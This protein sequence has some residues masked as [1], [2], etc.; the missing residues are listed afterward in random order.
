MSI[1]LAL[2]LI[3]TPAEDHF[4]AGRAHHKVGRFEL[5]IEEYQ[6][7]YELKPT[8]DLLFNIGQCHRNLKHVERAIFFFD[9][10]LQEA[11]NAPD[12]DAVR[13]LIGELQIE[14][15]SAKTATVAETVVEPPPP[16]I[17]P[18]PPIEEETPLHEQWWFWTIIAIGVGALA[19]GA[20]AIAQSV[21]DEGSI[22]TID[23]R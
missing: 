3:A 9:R 15:E 19:G 10:Y 13:K 18:P 22:G 23:A 8:P 20:V 4:E 5:A 1:A 21:G 16:A 14:L 2:L 17:V 11:P 6:K 7:A 12:A